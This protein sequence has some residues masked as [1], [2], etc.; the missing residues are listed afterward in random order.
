[1]VVSSSSVSASGVRLG[2]VVVEDEEDVSL[3]LRHTLAGAGFEVVVAADLASARAAIAAMRPAVIVLDRMLPDGDGLSFCKE[4]RRG[5]ERAAVL[6]LSALGSEG[7][8]VD[9]LEAGADDYV[10]KPFSVREV[11]ARVHI[12]STLIA[13][14]R[15]GPRSS[16]PASLLQWRGLFVDKHRHR[17]VIDGVETELRPLEFKLLVELLQN[18]ERAF[19]RTQLLSLL[20]GDEERPSAR[21]VDVHVTRLR[22]NLGT[23][24][25]CVETVPGYGYRLR[26]A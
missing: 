19:S 20:W 15:A 1:M 6:L 2:V 10:V 24:G 21:T 25:D 4:L 3:L 18:P 22:H 5:Q 13:E 23:H 8:R 12:L 17:V 26:E 11:A 7:D 9:G 14:R 16:G